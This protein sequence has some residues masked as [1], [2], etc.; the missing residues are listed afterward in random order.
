MPNNNELK[1][2]ILREFHVK[3]YLG[4]SEYHKILIA[5]KNFYYWPN[6]KKEVT[7][8]VAKCLDCQ[9]VKSKCKNPVG[10]LQLISI[11]KWKWEV[12]SMDFI[13]GLLRKSRQNDS[14]MVLVDRLRKVAHFIVVKSTNSS[15]KAAQTFIKEISSL[16]GVP[17]RIIS[18]RVSK[19]TS[20]Y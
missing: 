13:T 16:H 5:I 20:K 18:D 15:R 7:K 3:P 1:K 2:L 14:I 11:P 19:F 17:K 6:L 8:F 4:H 10:L 9:W 12:I